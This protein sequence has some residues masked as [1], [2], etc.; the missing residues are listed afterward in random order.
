MLIH[1]LGTESHDEM[2]GIDLVFLHQFGSDFIDSFREM[3][4][5]GADL[6]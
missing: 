6:V 4:K 1:S 2:V 3:A 5:L